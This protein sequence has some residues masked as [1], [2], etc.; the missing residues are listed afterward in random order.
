MTSSLFIVYISIYFSQTIGQ[1]ETQL[2]RKD[3]LVLL[4]IFYDFKFIQNSAWLLGQLCFLIG[5]DFKYLLP[6]TT[7]DAAHFIIFH[8]HFNA[9]FF[10]KLIV[11]RHCQTYIALHS[12]SV[13]IV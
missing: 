8:S 10:L 6:E 11:L 13:V 9:F 4:D 1:I 12:F 2:D 7:T 5:S 3:T